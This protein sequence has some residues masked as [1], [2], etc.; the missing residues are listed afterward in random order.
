MM[1]KAKSAFSFGDALAFSSREVEFFRSDDEQAFEIRF[2]QAMA[3][4]VGT[5]SVDGVEPSDAPVRTSVYSAVIP[6]RGKSTRASFMVNG[7]GLTEPGTR[8][9][10]FMSL[11][12]QHTVT[13]FPGGQK[14]QD[15]VVALPFSGKEIQDV[16]LTV[17][18]IAERDAAHPDASALVAITDISA[19]AA[20]AANKKRA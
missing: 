11:N 15:F 18:L 7:F 14:D 19:D 16:R 3:I 9:T 1:S 20:L 6:V 5:A 10:L 13:E 17:V 8:A 2:P 4:A 12:D